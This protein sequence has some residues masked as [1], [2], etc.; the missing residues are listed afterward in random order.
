MCR[1]GTLI[2]LCFRSTPVLG[3]IDQPIAGDR[4]LGAHGHPTVYNGEPVVFTHDGDVPSTLAASRCVVSGAG[5]GALRD[6]GYIA[7]ATALVAAVTTTSFTVNAYAYGLLALGAIELAFEAPGACRY[8]AVVHC[9]VAR[10][11]R[12]FVFLLLLLLLCSHWQKRP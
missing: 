7:A 8:S 1:W 2:G 12:S 3:V 11:L 10:P 9:L 6:A 5:F 4:W